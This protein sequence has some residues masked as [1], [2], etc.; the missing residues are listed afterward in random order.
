[1]EQFSSNSVP[2]IKDPSHLVRRHYLQPEKNNNMLSQDIWKK[3]KHCN[4]VAQL[5]T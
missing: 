1:M 5:T 4:W 3:S 2:T